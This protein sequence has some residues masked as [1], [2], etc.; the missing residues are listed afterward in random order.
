MEFSSARLISPKLRQYAIFGDSQ[1]IYKLRSTTL[2]ILIGTMLT[3]AC[4]VAEPTPYRAVYKATYKGVPI[5]ATGIR[6]LKQNEN[7]DYVLSSIA[8]AFVATVEESTTFSAETDNAVRPLEYR[9]DRRGIG[10]KRSDL[11]RFDWDEMVVARVSESDAWERDMPAGVQ[12]KLSYQQKMR[13]ELLAAFEAGEDWPVMTYQVAEDDGRIRE[14]TFRVVGEEL[15]KVPA[16]T[17]NTI[18]AE[19]VR[20]H[21]RRTTYFWLAPD[22]E[23]LLV[24]FEHSEADGDGFKLLLKN[25]ELAGKPISGD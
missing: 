8:R 17:F 13:E 14:Y 6:E 16:G 9:Y 2:L 19:R 4:A 21:N 20:D 10:R 12:D 11:L 5:S 1:G 22:H 25:A 15:I 18:K 3:G 7:G 24:R 23:F